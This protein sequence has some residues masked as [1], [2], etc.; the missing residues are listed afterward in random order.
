MSAAKPRPSKASAAR[1]A[2]PAAT[3]AVPLRLRSL[4]YTPADRPERYTKAWCEGAADAVCADLEDAVAPADKDRARQMVVAALRAVPKAKALRAVRVNAIGSEHHEADVANALAAGC[5]LLVV[6][7]CEDAEP[8]ARL[9]ARVEREAVGPTRVVAI[10]E[11]ARGVVNARELCAVGGLA[12]V[13]FGAED[14]AADA[15][16]RRSADNTEVLAARQWV[17]L[18]AA[19]A[20]IQAIDMITADVK[21]LA[22]V[23]REAREA[24]AWGY[25]GKMLVHPGQVPGVHAAFRPSEAEVAWARKV[26]AAVDAAHVGAGGVVLVDGRMVDV[27]VI[28][29]ARRV[30][31]DL[32]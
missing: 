24:R 5:D 15:G 16:L 22:R 26:L 21:D 9:A 7:K 27:P 25:R 18:C 23:E 8:L 32:A 19:A 2:K 1:P 28:E 14:L 29:Q 20:G 17:A 3:P 4:L 11:T 31:A 13:C 30:I 10:V 6:P 12:A